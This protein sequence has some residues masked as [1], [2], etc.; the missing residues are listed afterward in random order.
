MD[1]NRAAQ[2]S[3]SDTL[4]TLMSVLVLVLGLIAAAGSRAAA[5]LRSE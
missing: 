2:H 5:I 1:P 3:T 4:N